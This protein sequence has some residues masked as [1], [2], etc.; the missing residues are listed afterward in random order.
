MVASTQEGMGKP[1]TAPVQ[2]ANSTETASSEVSSHKELM[3]AEDRETTLASRPLVPDPPGDI[4]PPAPGKVAKAAA[5]DDSKSSPQEPNSAQSSQTGSQPAQGADSNKQGDKPASQDGKPDQRLKSGSQAGQNSGS[6]DSSANK[7]PKAP[8]RPVSEAKVKMKDRL[9]GLAD[10]ADVGREKEQTVARDGKADLGFAGTLLGSAAST[11]PKGQWQE[12]RVYSTATGKHVFSKVT[13]TVYADEN[14]KHE[15][16]V[17]D[18]SPTSVS[19]QLLRSAREM[20]RSRPVTWM[21]AAVE[22]FG[23]D[24]L[25][26]ILYR[27]LS[28]DFEERI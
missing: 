8:P 13:R 16:D 24:P 2:G 11:A 25:A 6:N 5:G 19:T 23:Y 26:K 10:D 21:D 4:K 22:F 18:P 7:A 20:T 12:L 14:D 1:V 28:V 27:K 17:F 15:A 9:P 3:R